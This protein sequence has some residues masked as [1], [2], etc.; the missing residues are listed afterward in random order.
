MTYIEN[1]FICL[2]IPL[3]LSLFFTKGRAR[4]F[5]LFLTVGMGVCLLGAYVSSFFMGYYGVD[6]TVAAK[7][8]TSLSTRLNSVP[9]MPGINLPER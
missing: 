4:S 9:I 8:E 3:I 1:I 6:T 5:T 2:A 7:E